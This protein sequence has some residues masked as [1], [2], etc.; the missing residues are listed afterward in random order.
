MSVLPDLQRIEADLRRACLAAISKI[1]P[2]AD[3]KILNA[4]IAHLGL[5]VHSV[6]DAEFLIKLLERRS[7]GLLGKEERDPMNTRNERIIMAANA[8]RDAERSEAE[9]MAASQRAQAD[10]RALLAASETN[11]E[12]ARRL[13]QSA[14]SEMLSAVLSTTD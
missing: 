3:A 10:L 5:A 1:V 2:V 4:A 9:I 6:A 14:Y 13:T 8:Y 7:K 12:N 11:I